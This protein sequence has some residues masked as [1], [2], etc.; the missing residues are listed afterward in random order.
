MVFLLTLHPAI[1]V[2]RKNDHNIRSF[3][4]KL[5]IFPHKIGENHRK[6]TVFITQAPEV[7]EQ[8][9]TY[10]TASSNSLHIKKIYVCT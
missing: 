9:R 1:Y 2:Y 6:Y 4:S 8:L 10:I 3:S 5:L 7:L